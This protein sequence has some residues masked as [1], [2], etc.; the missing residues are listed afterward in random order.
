M[1]LGF[2]KTFLKGEN[3]FKKI[4]DSIFPSKITSFF[5]IIASVLHFPVDHGLPFYSIE[6]EKLNS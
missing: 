6:A 5:S 1:G 3:V 4:T 2:R